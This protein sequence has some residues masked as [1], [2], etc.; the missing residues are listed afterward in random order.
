MSRLP[1]RSKRTDPLFPYTT[2]F[3]SGLVLI[4]NGGVE[5]VGAGL[6]PELRLAVGQRR[7]LARRR[8]PE[9]V[10]RLVHG[11]RILAVAHVG[12]ELDFVVAVSELEC[13]PCGLGGAR[14]GGHEQRCGQPSKPPFG[15]GTEEG[16][17]GEEGC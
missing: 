8:A 6:E 12:R 17:G 2:L 14:Q 16:R 15:G 5:P 9:R 10:R 11:A 3:R 7:E 13:G 4:A 1:P